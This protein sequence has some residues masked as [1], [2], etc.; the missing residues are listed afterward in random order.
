[1][2]HRIPNPK[3]LIPTSL[4]GVLSVLLAPACAACN[5]VLTT[6]LSGCVCPT[7]WEAIVPVD[8]L[9]LKEGS[10]MTAL[11]S[12]GAY[13]GTLRD[14]IH[15]L[16]YRGRRSIA[17]HLAGIM[18]RTARDL[19]STADCV[20]PVPLHWRREYARGFNQAR[21]IAQHLGLPMIEALKRSR[22]TT[23]QVAL[24]AGERHAN[25]AGAFAL[26]RKPLLHAAPRLEGCKT[27][28]IDDVTTTGA[29][30]EACARIL[31]A[32]GA[33]EVYGLTAARTV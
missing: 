17:A 10:A 12:L 20:V 27:V 23:P 31:K 4:N 11:I 5:A 6:L 32:A 26:R 3:S 19:L 15:A 25:V 28:L 8:E 18:R 2:T 21:E 24:S 7:C 13:D 1:M 29:T 9:V 14:M 22:A 33:A 30:L 16:K